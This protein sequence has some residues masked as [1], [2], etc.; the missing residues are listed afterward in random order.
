MRSDQGPDAHRTF[1]RAVDALCLSR[2]EIAR[3]LGI[4]EA[5]LERFT[6]G[7]ESVPPVTQLRL[8]DVLKAHEVTLCGAAGV[9]YDEA[10]L[11]LMGSGSDGASSTR[12][13]VPPRPAPTLD[14][15]GGSR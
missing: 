2:E 13:R 8:V 3:E 15:D 10:M 9:L 1:E 12:A 7:D 11:R 5:A 6:K 4:T 14:R